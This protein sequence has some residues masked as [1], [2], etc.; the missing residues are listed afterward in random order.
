[1]MG[2]FQKIREKI[3]DMKAKRA[4]TM[5]VNLGAMY[6]SIADGSAKT[7]DPRMS[8]LE[9]Q[10]FQAN[11]AKAISEFQKNE[12]A[13]N[14]ADKALQDYFRNQA[15]Q[16]MKVNGQMEAPLY[17]KSLGVSFPEIMRMT[18]GTIQYVRDVNEVA[19]MTLEK[20]K[21]MNIPGFGQDPIGG[22]M[23]E[24]TMIRN[25]LI[26][27][28]Q[29]IQNAM[30]KRAVELY[31][32]NNRN[33]AMMAGMNVLTPQAQM[34]VNKLQ[35]VLLE[36]PEIIT[37]KMQA[38]YNARR[39]YETYVQLVQSGADYSAV[40]AAM[41]DGLILPG[42][43]E[44]VVDAR[45]D[46]F[47]K[48]FEANGHSPEPSLYFLAIQMNDF[49]DVVSSTTISEM[50]DELGLNPNKTLVYDK[51]EPM[52]V[53]DM[54]TARNLMGAESMA[55][56]VSLFKGG[57][58]SGVVDQTMLVEDCAMQTA[59]GQ[60]L[61]GT[62]VAFANGL[63][64]GIEMRFNVDEKQQVNLQVLLFHNAPL[65]K[66]TLLASKEIRSIIGSLP[67][68]MQKQVY[69]SYNLRMENGQLREAVGATAQ[70]AQ[71]IADRKDKIDRLRNSLESGFQVTFGKA[72][73]LSSKEQNVEQNKDDHPMT[74]W[75]MG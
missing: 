34:D 39:D 52:K 74:G 9:I 61:W 47:Y 68:A 5:A 23:R 35:S 28:R 25:D 33:S 69:Q 16:E 51:A 45:L 73:E 62:T 29:K 14:N 31:A 57:L 64:T 46:I 38:L 3:E 71:S 20:G 32:Q 15:F 54:S 58:E 27:N 12:Q 37:P 59:D 36:L 56:F 8:D 63:P 48:E 70:A 10:N 49:N 2:F 30:E 67:P 44:S 53:F 18:E 75:E 1:M 60:L 21:M 6:Q 40:R 43:P 50:A 72:E 66:D 19:K 13:F 11:M 26:A 65:D 24:A 22:D 42:E 55:N 4:D 7:T 17:F 41:H